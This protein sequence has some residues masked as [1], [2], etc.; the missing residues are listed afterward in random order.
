LGNQ[1]ALSNASNELNN[2]VLSDQQ[3]VTETFA[4]LFTE[5]TNWD[6]T[7]LK[8]INY[9]P[10][11]ILK[12]LTPTER[13]SLVGYPELSSKTVGDQLLS[14]RL[15]VGGTQS[16]VGIISD[17]TLSKEQKKASLQ[18]LFGLLPADADKLVGGDTIPL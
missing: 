18:L 5:I 14:E 9:I 8:P 12:D 13:R 17:P 11:A 6:I 1:E 4:L 2:D 16:L 7:S 10:D 3:L 15:G